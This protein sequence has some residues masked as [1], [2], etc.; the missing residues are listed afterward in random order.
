M[1]TL[2]VRRSRV[3]QKMI[4][5]LSERW[6]ISQLSDS[7]VKIL[8][9]Y[10]MADRFPPNYPWSLCNYSTVNSTILKSITKKKCYTMLSRLDHNC[11]NE[12]FSSNK[13]EVCISSKFRFREWKNLMSLIDHEDRSPQVSVRHKYSTS[14]LLYT[15]WEVTSGFC[16]QNIGP[17]WVLYKCSNQSIELDL[18]RQFD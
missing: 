8:T 2:I 14:D 18:H 9:L 10:S 7:S 11:P 15:V 16:C 3:I 4:S 12:E 17:F 5:V 6:I 13:F 1:Y